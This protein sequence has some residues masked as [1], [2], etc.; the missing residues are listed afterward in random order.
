MSSDLKS[1]TNHNYKH[2]GNS[3]WQRESLS[4]ENDAFQIL[5][6]AATETSSQQRQKQ[7]KKLTLSRKSSISSNTSISS[8]LQRHKT[9]H[10]SSLL[11]SGFCRFRS[12][13]PQLAS[14]DSNETTSALNFTTEPDSTTTSIQLLISPSKSSPVKLQAT[15]LCISTTISFK[16]KVEEEMLLVPI[17]RKKLNDINMRWLAEEA[18][19]RYYNLVGLK[20]L[21]RLKTADG[22]AYEDNDP[23]NVAVEQNMI[24]ATVLE[25]QISPL[26]NRY[27]EMCIQLHKDVNK[28][29]MDVLQRAQISNTIQLHDF[30]LSPT[31]T[32]PVF[33][34]VL[35]QSNL[36]T[37]DLGNNFI[38]NEGCRQLAKALSTLKHLKSLNLSGNF[39]TSDGLEVLLS[40]TGSSITLEELILSQ[41]PLRNDSI[42]ILDR[43]C[44][45]PAGKSIHKLH[46][47]HCS[48]TQLYDYDLNYYEL[49][50][51]DISFNHLTDDVLQVL[52][53]KLN[54]CRLQNLNLSYIN[55]LQNDDNPRI[56]STSTAERLV[57][58]FESGTCE[59]F[60]NIELAACQLND[61]DIYKIVLCLS[62]SN[63]LEL[64]NIS[65]NKRITSSSLFFIF[66]KMSHLRKLE[67]TN[68]LRLFEI[69]NLDRLLHLQHIP[70][71]VSITVDDNSMQD[72]LHQLSILWQSHWGDRGK[73]KSYGN[74]IILYVNKN[75]ISAP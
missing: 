23:V 1:P 72:L 31:Q 30:W 55:F 39:I 9:K 53:S 4:P 40:A 68:C 48:I 6:D 62:R 7:T 8:S 33:K 10:Q 28:N 36:R 74:N 56:S 11:D 15:S 14:E 42:R 37:L 22:F 3:P 35:H 65:D 63:D 2:S 50:D 45:G 5:L 64:F 32:E 44:K 20:P 58:F 75:D 46:L 13:S 71:Y 41:N 43:F 69:N 25:W 34:A 66:D 57:D 16:V 60:R 26:G 17:E 49:Y 21:L 73:I 47:S 19:R 61:V 51:F 70:N 12:E 18:A 29:V 67:A 52:L 38:Q 24:L 59:K 54:S 27:E